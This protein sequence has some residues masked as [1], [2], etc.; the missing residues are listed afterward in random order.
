MEVLMDM[1]SYV[2]VG[3]PLG[4]GRID[5]SKKLGL[6]LYGRVWDCRYFFTMS[7]CSLLLSCS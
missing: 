3:S 1:F 6:L 2:Y 5:M 4:S 7:A